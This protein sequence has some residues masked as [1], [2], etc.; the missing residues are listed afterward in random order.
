MNRID[1]NGV[2]YEDRGFLLS[3]HVRFTEWVVWH[4]KNGE[5]VLLL[6]MDEQNRWDAT[7]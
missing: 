4:E 5:L 2:S 6:L 7:V 1:K 3:E